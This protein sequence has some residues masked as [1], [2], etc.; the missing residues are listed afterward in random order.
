V[1]RSG[2]DPDDL[3]SFYVVANYRTPEA[4]VLSKS[5]AALFVAH[6]LGWPWQAACLFGGVP[7]ALLD[8]VYGVVARNRYRIFGRHER[9]LIPRPEYRDR[10][11][12]S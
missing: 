6:V 11:V 7:T 8:T 1:Q 9:C 2:S 12:D 10:F 3:T 4:R 5:R